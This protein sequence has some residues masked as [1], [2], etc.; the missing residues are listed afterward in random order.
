M[1]LKK[2][3]AKRIQSTTWLPKIITI[4]EALKNWTG[5][6]IADPLHVKFELLKIHLKLSPDD[7]QSMADFVGYAE[8]FVRDFDEIDQYLVDPK[9]LFSYLSEAKAMELWHIDGTD[10]TQSER[11]FMRFYESIINYY[12]LLKEKLLAEKSGYQ[13]MLARILAESNTNELV[14]KV[15]VEKVIFAGFNALTK[16][17]EKIVFTLEQE[18]KAEILWDIDSYYLQSNG[19]E[20]PEAGFFL[21]RFLEKQNRRTPVKWVTENILKTKKRFFITGI[22]G[23]VGQCKALGNKLL[24]E[25]NFESTAVILADENLL[26]PTINSIPTNVG[27]FNVTMG[28]PFSKSQVY[29]FLIKLIDFHVFI[30][31]SSKNEGFYIWTVVHLFDLEFFS[32]ILNPTELKE[33]ENI[34]QNLIKNGKTFVTPAEIYANEN[35]VQDLVLLLSAIFEPW[36]NNPVSCLMQIQ[37]ILEQGILRLKLKNK[38]DHNYLLL[39][40][41]SAGI[42]ICKRLSDL[43][44][45]NEHL[46]DIQSIRQLIK[47]IAPSYTINFFGEPLSGLQLMGL[48]ESRNLDFKTLHLLSVNE[49]LL[50]AEKH[51]N[52][53]VPSDIRQSFA[54]PTHAHKQAVFAYHFYRLLQSAENIHI[55]YNTESGEIGGG[56]KSRFIL[57]I[58]HEIAKLNPLFEIEET[59]ST[60]PLL[61]TTKQKPVTG[62]KTP[63]IIQKIRNK[64]LSGFSASSLSTYLN[65]QLKFY[66]TELLEIREETDDNEIIGFNT[67]GNILHR[68]LKDLYEGYQNILLNNNVYQ[69]SDTIIA[70]AFTNETKSELPEFGKNKLI[71][72]V[73]KKLWDDYIAF[74]KK[75]IGQGKE[76]KI[77]DLEKKY[78]HPMIINSAEE[79]MPW[80]LKGTIDRVD[81]MDGVMRIIDFKTGKVEDKDLKIGDISRDS[82]NEKPK[83]LQ[84][85]IYYYLLSKNNP[86][87]ENR[88]IILGLYKLLRSESGFMLFNIPETQANLS[89]IDEIEMMLNLIVEEIYDPNL[90][91]SQTENQDHCRYC[92][93]NDICERQINDNIH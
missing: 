42:R 54:L 73:I 63:E 78:E 4:E 15:N 22:P 50:P 55:Y 87:P 59:I 47:Q 46:V 65:C 83:A 27:V 79:I 25:N 39:N 88:H 62:I 17:E 56:E 14:D 81:L 76:I 20:L 45:G 7:K 21:R 44:T 48:L 10:L 82:V 77:L 13:G 26:L 90:T 30:N 2:E 5:F 72:E 29:N 16:A 31:K 38:N 75:Q 33:I 8:M 11:N 91:F 69:N 61:Q 9:A 23:N 80:K 32:H 3:L 18:G 36:K 52:S 84:L 85:L 71:L 51:N 67:I 64:A 53:F 28:L 60:I 57:Q 35:P 70:R 24:H 40:Q 68:A 37:S 41:F 58:K 19:F 12:N 74:E 89:L 34:K 92:S 66:L 43:V 1:F 86:Y 93:F 49:G 6:Q